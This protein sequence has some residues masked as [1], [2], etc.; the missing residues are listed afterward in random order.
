MKTIMATILL[1]TLIFS[2]SAIAVRL[3]QIDT[4]KILNSH[5]TMY[6]FSGEA[7]NIGH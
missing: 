3:L 1:S 6:M 5:L 7:V 2:T 4:K